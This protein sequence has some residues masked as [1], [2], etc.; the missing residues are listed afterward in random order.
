MSSKALTIASFRPY[1]WACRDPSR[2]LS[3]FS[4]SL[5]LLC[6]P[7]HHAECG[8]RLSNAFALRISRLL[9]PAPSLL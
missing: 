8:S 5:L 3:L 4:S 6:L 7:E 2:A 9:P 1:R